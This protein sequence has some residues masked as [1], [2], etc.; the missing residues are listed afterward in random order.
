M[1]DRVKIQFMSLT[2]R[3]IGLGIA[4]K[5][6]PEY[7]F[8][9]ALSDSG[10]LTRIFLLFPRKNFSCTEIRR[11]QAINYMIAN[12]KLDM[13]P[14]MKYMTEYSYQFPEGKIANFWQT[15]Q[16]NLEKNIPSSTIFYK[17]EVP[18]KYTFEIF[19]RMK[20]LLK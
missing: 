10:E 19:E 15:Y 5:V 7:L 3:L 18:K 14:F 6:N 9:E 17:V 16:K 1:L 13:V 2:E 20:E 12:L 8:P 4:T 11:E